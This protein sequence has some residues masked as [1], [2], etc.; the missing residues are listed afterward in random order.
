MNKY[1]EKVS[2]GL[3]KY[4][5][6]NRLFDGLWGFWWKVLVVYHQ[7]RHAKMKPPK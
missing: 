4:G 5:R 3:K 7:D 1:S 2:E 6:E